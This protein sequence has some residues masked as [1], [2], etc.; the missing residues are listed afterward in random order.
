M[1]VANRLT[2]DLFDSQ[3]IG[4]LIL[5]EFSIDQTEVSGFMHA[6]SPGKEVLTLEEGYTVEVLQ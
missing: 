6:A 4:I 1:M 5:A 2:M 3:D